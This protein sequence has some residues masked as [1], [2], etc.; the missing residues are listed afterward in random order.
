MADLKGKTVVITGATSGMGEAAALT[1]ARQEA[2]VLVVGRNSACGSAVIKE[3]QGAGGSGES[4]LLSLEDIA[5][6]A[7]EII[8]RRPTIDV[9]INNAGGTFR[10]RTTSAD[11]IEATF[12]LTRWLPSR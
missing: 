8:A 6:L 11:G 3:M 2:H 9:L 12:A 4:N 7:E 10:T 1:F 5:R